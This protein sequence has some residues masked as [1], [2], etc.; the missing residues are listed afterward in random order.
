MK[1]QTRLPAIVLLC[2]AALPQVTSAHPGHSLFS[3][4]PTHLL[5]NPDHLLTMAALGTRTLVLTSSREAAAQWRRELRAR[6]KEEQRRRPFSSFLKTTKT[7]GTGLGL[8]I[9]GRIIET[10]QGKV[11]IKSSS[12]GTR[13]SVILPM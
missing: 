3:H 4:G 2:L 6:M 12:R 5:T 1:H 8:A 7:K 13:V 9:V 10:H 11:K